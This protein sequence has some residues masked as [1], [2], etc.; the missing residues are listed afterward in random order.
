M[1]PQELL[2]G[3]PKKVRF[4]DWEAGQAVRC[5]RDFATALPFHNQEL[6]PQVWTYTGNN[7]MRR[8]GKRTARYVEIKQGAHIRWVP[9]SNYEVV[10][11]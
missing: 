3:I 7:E 1:T 6:L 8:E 10:P 11:E 9:A 5:R 4:T 2:A